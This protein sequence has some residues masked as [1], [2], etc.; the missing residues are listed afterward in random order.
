MPV[1]MGSIPLAEILA[2][3]L[4][5]YRGVLMMELRSRY[6]DHLKESKENL[7]SLLRSIVNADW[8]ISQSSS[9]A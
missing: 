9:L 5:S 2:A 7:I 1:G 6:F 8:T 3:Y 4:P